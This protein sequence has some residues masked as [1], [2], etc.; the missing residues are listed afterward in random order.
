MLG[1]DAAA[2]CQPCGGP[3]QPCCRGNVCQDGLGCAGSG[4]LRI[5]NPCGDPG[6][7]CCTRGAPCKGEGCCFS[8]VCL[9]PGTPC[10]FEAP[11]VSVNLGRCAAG[12]CDGCGGPGQPC[13]PP[14]LRFQPACTLPDTVCTPAPMMEPAPITVFTSPGLCSRCGVPGGP[15]CPRNR[16]A[17]GGC[18][19]RANPGENGTCVA[20]ES[21]C[22]AGSLCRGGACGACGAAGFGCCGQSCTAPDTT[23][24]VTTVVGPTCHT[25]GERGQPCCFDQLAAPACQGGLTCRTGVCW[26][27]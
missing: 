18:C 26:E 16:C 14:L 25:C 20:Q 17:D 19:V 21:A 1:C 3:R 5:C 12:A 11:G 22:G 9:P 27:R 4:A 6:G 24:R 2:T 13:C 8:T 15:C 7:A 10:A 23:C